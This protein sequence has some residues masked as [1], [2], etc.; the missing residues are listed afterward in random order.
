[1]MITIFIGNALDA[2]DLSPMSLQ[3]STMVSP[4]AEDGKEEITVYG[5]KCTH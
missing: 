2:Q 3:T 5:I 4:S 1:M